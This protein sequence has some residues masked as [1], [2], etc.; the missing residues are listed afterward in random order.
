MANKTHGMRKTPTYR[1]WKSMKD[2]C[3]NPNH[4]NYDIYKDKKICKRWLISF[5]N[6]LKDMGERPRGTTLNRI[7]N[8]LGYCK[9][10]CNW[11]TY[12]EQS[13]NRRSYSNTGQKHISA[14][15][16]SGHVRYF[17]KIRH[18]GEDIRFSSRDIKIAIEKRDEILLCLGRK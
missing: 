8:K 16:W 6:F 13:S 2:R 4:K 15:I 12:S 7:N 3:L 5:D 17:V 1:S 10:N 14:S 11:A 9:K 18:K